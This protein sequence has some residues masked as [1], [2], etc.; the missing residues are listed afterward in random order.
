MLRVVAAATSSSIWN[1][2][3]ERPTSECAMPSPFVPSASRRR[4]QGIPFA[5]APDASDNDAREQERFRE[6]SG[7][8]SRRH[9]ARLCLE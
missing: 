6:C 5:I 7:E 2:C 1:L 8:L 3:S 4:R 9:L